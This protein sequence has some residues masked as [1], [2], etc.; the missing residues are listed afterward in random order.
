MELFQANPSGV[1]YLP[2]SFLAMSLTSLSFLR[3]AWSVPS[4][5]FQSD[6]NQHRNQ[7]LAISVEL[8]WDIRISVS[9]PTFSCLAFEFLFDLTSREGHLGQGVRCKYPFWGSF[10]IA[11][12]SL[13][14][15]FKLFRMGALRFRT[16][17]SAPVIICAFH[18]QPLRPAQYSLLVS[19]SVQC[20]FFI[21]NLLWAVALPFGMY[22]PNFTHSALH[23]G[24]GIPCYFIDGRIPIR[25]SSGVLRC[26][27]LHPTLTF[28]IS[29][30]S[31]VLLR[32]V[33][34]RSAGYSQ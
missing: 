10:C 11:E 22:V 16:T 1:C 14:P 26:Y 2:L 5:L 15:S 6:A 4:S 18:F 13:S 24:I 8:F 32:I 12:I 28:L 30:R 31:N 21:F 19:E 29:S 25:R 23:R 9:N 7:F 3:E 27:R 34:A 17:T 33:A 20:S